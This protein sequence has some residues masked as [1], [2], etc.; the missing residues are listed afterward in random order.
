MHKKD[1]SE[2]KVAVPAQQQHQPQPLQAARDEGLAARAVLLAGGVLDGGESKPDGKDENGE[3]QGL[4][5]A[6][7]NAGIVRFYEA[8]LNEPIPEKMLRL[9]KEIAKREK[10]S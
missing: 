7:F 2:D 1:E 10:E 3:Q 4:D 6:R 8:I 5:R 9:V